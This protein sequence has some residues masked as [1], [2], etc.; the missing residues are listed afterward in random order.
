MKYILFVLAI[1]PLTYS[2]STAARAQDADEI[3]VAGNPPL[4]RRDA[5]EVIR[6]YERGLLVEFD[7]GQRVELMDKLAA[8]WKAGQQSNGQ[9][10]SGFLKVVGKINA[11]DEDKRA[12]LQDELTRTVLADLKNSSNSQFNR[13]VLS[14]YESARGESPAAAR[15]DGGRAA[16]AAQEEATADAGVAEAGGQSEENFRPVGG[17]LRLADLAGRWMKDP[18]S[19]STSGYTITTNDKGGYKNNTVYEVRAD[20]SFDFTANTTLYMSNCKTEL[21]TTRKGRIGVSGS[22]ANVSYVS[23]TLQSKDNCSKRGN[24]TKALGAERAEFPYR[25][26]RDGGQLRLCTV[27]RPEP[28]CLYKVR[29]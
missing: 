12:R 16:A 15:A 25:L 22:Q 20:G 3:L 23:G 29:Q 27:G 1:L 26:E 21:F 14:A 13:L 10:L 24:Y 9:S 4:T 2:I 5:E 28:N 8:S 17:P 18:Y 11:W 6:Y 19:V 7:A